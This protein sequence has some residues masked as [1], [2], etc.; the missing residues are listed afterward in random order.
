MDLGEQDQGQHLADAGD[1][2][3]AVEGLR[4]V[5]LGGPGQV[6]FQVGDLGVVGT[7]GLFLSALTHWEE[8]CQ[9][10]LVAELATTV[11]GVLGRRVRR[12]RTK[13]AA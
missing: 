7:E 3:Q 12:F 9:L 11:Q 13:N 5:H 6:Q 8:L 1:G 4:V 2:T 10:L